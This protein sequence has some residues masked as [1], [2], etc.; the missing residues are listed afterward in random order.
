MDSCKRKKANGVNG[1]TEV[2]VGGVAPGGGG[3]RPAGPPLSL[4]S[5]TPSGQTGIKLRVGTLNVGTMTGKGMEVVGLM[6]RRKVGVLCVQE[7]RWK[8]NEARAMGDGYKMFYAGEASGRNGVGVVVESSLV[9]SVVGVERVSSRL[10]MVKLCW[11]GIFVNVVSAYAPQTGLGKEE[12]EEFWEE[13]DGLM[14]KIEK[15]ERLVIGADL[16]GHVGRERADFEEVH[17]GWGFGTRNEEGRS[18]LEAA[19]VH[20]LVV[21]NTWFKRREGQLVTFSRQGCETQIDYMLVRKDQRKECVNCKVVRDEWQGQHSLVV[22]DMIVKVVK[23][24]KVR[25]EGEVIKWFSMSKKEGELREKLLTEVE[26]RS[27]GTV[28]EAWGTV[29]ECVRRC[30]REVLGVTRKGRCKVEKESWWWGDEVQE[31]VKKKR[32]LYREWRKNK[33]GRLGESTEKGV[34]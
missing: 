15:G 7:V 27:R 4:V 18:I 29:A 26:W 14:G 6:E 5:E 10:M 13:W 28:E 21:V 12:K 1:S 24:R 25:N 3:G 34:V 17:G 16:N 19:V 32:V 22:L 33:G 31:A 23:R 30:A 11:N 20:E 9:E 8:G 2:S